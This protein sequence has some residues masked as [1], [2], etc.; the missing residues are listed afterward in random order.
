MQPMTDTLAKALGR[1][2]SDGVIV[3]SV[4]P[5]SPALAAGLKQGD[6]ITGINDAKIKEPRD[7]ALAVANI[8]AGDHADVHVWRAGITKDIRVAICTRSEERRVG[9]ERVSKR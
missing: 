9:K 6:V 1:P 3:N 2:D 7:L 5:D 4:L 8:H